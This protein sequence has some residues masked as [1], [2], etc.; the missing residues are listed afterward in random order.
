MVPRASSNGELVTIKLDI[1]KYVISQKSH[2]DQK[3]MDLTT[4]S[5]TEI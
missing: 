2:H 3:I 1:Q 4:E 5:G